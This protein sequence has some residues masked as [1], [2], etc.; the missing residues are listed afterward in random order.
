MGV[1]SRFHGSLLRGYRLEWNPT[2]LS[3]PGAACDPFRIFIIRALNRASNCSWIL[4]D[5][6][7]FVGATGRSFMVRCGSTRRL[8]W[9]GGEKRRVVGCGRRAQP[10]ART[11]QPALPFC[12]LVPSRQTRPLPH[13]GRPSEHREPTKR[14]QS[15][16]V[17]HLLAQHWAFVQSPVYN[18]Q[19]HVEPSPAR[20]VGNGTGRGRKGHGAEG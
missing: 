17:C 8:K 11:P 15:P 3:P 9:Q 18:E 10:G 19:S 7:R 5:C 16:P 13:K 1:V 6:I 2:L 20:C 14:I 12:T 4:E